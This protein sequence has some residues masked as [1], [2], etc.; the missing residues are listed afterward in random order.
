MLKT[1]SKKAKE[2]L[3]A[4]IITA[5]EYENPETARPWEAVKLDIIESFYFQVYRSEYEKKQ[6]RYDAF[7]GWLQGLPH[8][9]GDHYLCT[10]VDDLANILDET[11]TE[12]NRFTEDQAEEKLTRMIYNSIFY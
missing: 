11:E 1:N 12:R 8:G 2:N 3:K 7:K 9:L 4:Y 10:A 6:P 5:W